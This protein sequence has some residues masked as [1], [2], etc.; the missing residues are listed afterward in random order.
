MKYQKTLGPIQGMAMT[1]TTFVGTGLM[2]LPALSVTQSGAFSFYAWLITACIS[3]PIAFVFAFLGSRFPSA[4]GASHYIG[5]QFGET[6]ERAVGWLFL[7]IL[8]VGP[9][10]AIKI[11]A[12][13]LA[14][15]LNLDEHYIFALSIATLLIMTLYALAGAENSSKAQVYIVVMLIL[16]VISLA[17]KGNLSAATASIETPHDWV[18]WKTTLLS[19]G[20][21]FWCFLGLEVMAHLGAEFKNPA[22]DFPI[23][24]FGG[25]AIV[26]LLYLIV[27]LLVSYHHTYGDDLTN[28]QSLALL[29]GHLFGENS[30]RFFA[31]AAFIIAF[32]N[33]GMYLIGFARMVQT[34]AAKGAL[35]ST[36]APLSKKGSP[37]RA[38][39]L[40][41]LVSLLSL[42]TFHYTDGAM[43]MLI[44]MTNGAFILIYGLTSIT[45]L[46]LLKGKYRLFAVLA[47]VSCLLIASFMGTN[48]LFALGAFLFAILFEHYKDRKRRIHAPKIHV[49]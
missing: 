31:G 30:K 22:R 37:T 34:L 43:S 5:K 25:M 6:A 48:L 49:Q 41:S 10:V 12:A 24:L 46:H 42:L 47:C 28:S 7:S 18:S 2:L 13:Y 19:I 40:V 3:L 1:V 44:E 36:F 14:V 23:A 17:W 45:G 4:G 35:P 39:I 20:S 16:C 38:V 27:V 8:L 29:V 11:A 9:T 21:I 32:T 26:V 33:V 15:A